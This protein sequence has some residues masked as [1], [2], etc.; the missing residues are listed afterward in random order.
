M[1][2]DG[3]P[4]AALDPLR[5]SD[6][7]GGRA[8]PA[9]ALVEAFGPDVALTEARRR[10]AVDRTEDIR[11]GGDLLVATAH[12][13]HHFEDAPT[14]ARVRALA[15]GG[16]AQERDPRRLARYIDALSEL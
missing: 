2:Q 1:G 13:A 9:C 4:D 16:L 7:W 10:M 5:A 3:I 6:P 14:L 8:G 11:I 15:S 12:V